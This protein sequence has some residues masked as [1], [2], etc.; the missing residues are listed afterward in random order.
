LGVAT[1]LATIVDCQDPRSQADFW[2]TVLSFHVNERNTDEYRVNG[3]SAGGPSLYFMKVTE[4]KVV[5]NRLHLD[6]ITEGSMESEVARLVEL[7]ASVIEARAD[8]DSLDHPDTWT[9]MK[10]PEGNEFCVTSTRTLT[11]WT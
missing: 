4:P 11:G 6:L 3:A 5:K 8:P 10:D 2:A 9:V 1:V 7:G